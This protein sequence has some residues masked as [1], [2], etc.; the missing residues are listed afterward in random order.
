LKSQHQHVRDC[1]SSSSSFLH[2]VYPMRTSHFFHGGWILLLVLIP[3][4]RVE[5][6]KQCWFNDGNL[7]PDDIPCTGLTTLDDADVPCCGVNSTCLENRM[8]HSNDT[9]PHLSRGS[10]TDWQWQ[11]GNCP[12]FCKSSMC[13]S[14]VGS[15]SRLMSIS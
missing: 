12:Q 2:S 5:G 14:S 10:C 8:C 6:Q 13:L 9:L 4:V 11:S 7:T 15:S 1:I 3:L